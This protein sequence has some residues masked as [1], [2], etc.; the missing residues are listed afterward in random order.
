MLLFGWFG[1]YQEI[2]LV[3]RS[4]SIGGFL[5]LIGGLLLF[6]NLWSLQVWFTG[7]LRYGLL[8][9]RP[10]VLVPLIV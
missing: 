1:V 9:N 4:F 6:L 7:F 5:G 8:L 3:S 10:W 2:T